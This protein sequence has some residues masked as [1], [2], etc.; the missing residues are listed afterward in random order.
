MLD[1]I[2]KTALIE[3]QKISEQHRQMF[4]IPGFDGTYGAPVAIILSGNENT[5]QH[6]VV[7]AASAQ[8]M[9]IAAQSLGIS[10]C[11]VYFPIFIFHGEDSENWR[12]QLQ[13]PENYQPCVAILLG[14]GLEEPTDER[15][16]NEITYIEK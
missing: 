12:K 15:Y 10:S 5:I 16:K 13:I 3:G 2:N 11:W 9:L 7:C 1:R 14:Y 4:S 8:N 6:E